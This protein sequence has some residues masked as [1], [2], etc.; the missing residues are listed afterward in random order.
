MKSSPNGKIPLQGIRDPNWDLYIGVECQDCDN[1]LSPKGMKLMA[2]I[3]KMIED[4]PTWK[5][6]CLL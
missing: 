5:K 6:V 2:D 1:V 4:D 3:D